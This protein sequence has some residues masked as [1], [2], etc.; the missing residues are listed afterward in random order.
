M[1]DRL[2]PELLQEILQLAAP[3]YNE[4]TKGPR[5]MQTLSR[6]CLV[7]KSVGVVARDLF[8]REIEFRDSR[9]SSRLLRQCE[10]SPAQKELLASTTVVRAEEGGDEADTA[11]FPDV[12]RLLPNLRSLRLYNFGMDGHFELD[13]LQSPFELRI[14]DIRATLLHV[15]PVLCLPYLT[16]LTLDYAHIRRQHLANLLLP[17]TLPSLRAFSCAD[18]YDPDGIALQY[19]PELSSKML[20]QLEMVQTA[21]VDVEVLPPALFRSATPVFYTSSLQDLYSPGTYDDRYDPDE[22]NSESVMAMSKLQ[23]PHIR[24]LDDT[25]ER[26]GTRSSVAALDVLTRF[27][28][29]PTRP[30]SLHLPQ[31]PYLHAGDEVEERLKE[32][33]AL[34]EKEGVEVLWHQ[35]GQE[36][37]SAISSRLWKYAKR[38]KLEERGASGRSVRQQ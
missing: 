3:T 11:A 21:P 29:T 10:T 24:I 6:C 37:Y 32:F 36:M 38:L 8:W 7:S 34:C 26:V 13:R 23:L 17:A 19:F 2:P 5:R 20:G 22:D 33:L 1:L 16:H 12:L 18:T 14:L 4:G 28:S 25:R 27:L 35:E 31:R 9:S 15:P 30:R